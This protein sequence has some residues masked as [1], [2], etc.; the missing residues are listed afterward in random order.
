MKKIFLCAILLICLTAC[1]LKDDKDYKEELISYSSELKEY[2]LKA[3]MTVVKDEGE[4][5][6]DIVADY[7][8]PN[9]YKVKIQNKTNNNIQVIVKNDDGVYVLTPELNKQFKFNSDWP[10][11]S[12]HAY[13][14]Q[15]I[16]KD[17]TNDNDTT[18]MTDNE[19][20]IIKSTVNNKTNAKLK[21]QKT[22]FD[23]KTN[24]PIS[25]II[26]DA[27]EK[28]IIKVEFKSFTTDNKLK[29]SDFNVETINNTVRLE[30]A[31]GTLG[32][33]LLECVPTFIPTGY[34]LD[35]SIIKE[36]YTVFTYASDESVYTISTAVTETSKILTSTRVFDD[37]VNLD[38]TI[39]FVN[40]KSL[41]FFQED[42]FV[43][44]YNENFN[45][46]EAIL[47]ANSFK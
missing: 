10:L 30:L 23:K 5:S 19:N 1:D 7:L 41:S 4:I 29:P 24:A 47:I 36:T 44:I 31:E 11:N 20:Y 8:A 45:L 39:G 6:F 12:S 13:L 27:Q 3:K 38:N 25:N 26:Y 43:S 21:S 22:T 33:V 34:E 17:I 18:I 35:K 16:I 42:L 37:V 28:P 32:G 9:Y 2:N 15:S 40:E 14:Y 46:E